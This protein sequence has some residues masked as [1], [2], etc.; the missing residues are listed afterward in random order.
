MAVLVKSFNPAFYQ[1]HYFFILFLFPLLY[2]CYMCFICTTVGFLEDFVLTLLAGQHFSPSI[3]LL[4]L[5][6]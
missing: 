5:V 4:N 1:L 2:L 3:N 6:S